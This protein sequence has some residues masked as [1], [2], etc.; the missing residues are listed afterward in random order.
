MACGDTAS[1][2]QMK[3]LQLRSNNRPLSPPFPQGDPTLRTS[4]SSEPQCSPLQ[5]FYVPGTLLSASQISVHVLVIKKHKEINTIISPIL[6]MGKLKPRTFKPQETETISG[7]TRIQTQAAGSTVHA[8]NTKQTLLPHPEKQWNL[9]VT[10]RDPT[11]IKT[12]ECPDFNAAD[13]RQLK[14]KSDKEALS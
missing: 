13:E 11:A 8:P 14:T 10:L 6:G 3:I 12:L 1:D 7:R 4:G 2:S 5:L 9:P